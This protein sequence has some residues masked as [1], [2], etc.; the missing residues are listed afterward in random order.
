[1][2]DNIKN[3]PIGEKFLEN[4]NE[5]IESEYALQRMSNNKNTNISAKKVKPPS[6]ESTRSVHPSSSSR[7]NSKIDS[8]KQKHPPLVGSTKS[9]TKNDK[10]S[11]AKSFHELSDLTP[12]RS[13]IL[14]TRYS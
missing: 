2:A 3:W 5:Q 9:P 4:I 12:P 11:K 7:K 8:G 14:P 13:P 1:M 6:A 10:L